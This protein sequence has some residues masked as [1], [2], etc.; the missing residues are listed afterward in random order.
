[1][2][3]IDSGSNS[4]FASSYQDDLGRTSGNLIFLLFNI[5]IIYFIKLAKCREIYLLIY[6]LIEKILLGIYSI[7]MRRMLSVLAIMERRFDQRGRET[8]NS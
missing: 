3:Q 4:G 5:G 2:S 1:M 7:A 8:I 6:V